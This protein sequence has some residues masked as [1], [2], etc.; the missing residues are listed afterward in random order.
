M[1]LGGLGALALTLA[2]FGCDDG[3][4]GDA[5]PAQSTELTV[6]TYNAG[7][8][9]GFVNHAG[10]RVAAVAAAI[11][12]IEVDILCL[13]EVWDVPDR[14]AIEAGTGLQH[15]YN[16]PADAGECEGSA[17]S[18]E[19]VDPLVACYEPACADAPPGTIVECANANCPD[20]VAGLSGGCLGC[21]A[22]ALTDEATLEDLVGACGPD[23]AGGCYAYDGSFGTDIVSRYAL[24]DTDALV[25]ESS[26]NRRA[27]LYARVPDTPQGEVHV[28]CTHLSAVFENI[29]HPNQMDGGS[30]EAEQRAQIDAMRAWIDEKAGDGKVIVMGDFNT[31]PAVGDRVLAEVPENYDAL[32]AGYDPTYS[33]QDDAAC[34]FCGDNDLVTGVDRDKSVLLDHVLIRGFEGASTQGDIILDQGITLDIEGMSVPAALSVHYGVRVRIE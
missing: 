7:I 20:Q 3:D 10:P 22:G 25:F 28:F 13:Q 26:L 12:D 4:D 34:T 24:A 17:C 15:T 2:A 1:R 8:A 21:I 9:R 6:A 14:E 19:E 11:G 18:M 23:A 32:I 30:W 33:G 27:V 16:I 29:P 31:G 5:P